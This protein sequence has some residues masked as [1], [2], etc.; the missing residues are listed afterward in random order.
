MTN[1]IYT[2]ID[3]LFA[4]QAF[5]LLDRIRRQQNPYF[6]KFMEEFKKISSKM[7]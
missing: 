6:T 4:I 3:L 5:V 1:F 7:Y 2:N